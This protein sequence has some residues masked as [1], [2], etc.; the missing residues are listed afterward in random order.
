M[1][2]FENICQ[3]EGFMEEAAEGVNSSKKEHRNVDNEGKVGS[4]KRGLTVQPSLLVD[5]P[6]NGKRNSEDEITEVGDKERFNN[7]I[8]RAKS[9]HLIDIF[10]DIRTMLMKNW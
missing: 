3:Q 9:K 7:Y 2:G 6:E 5:I 8:M 10:E 1:K 4:V